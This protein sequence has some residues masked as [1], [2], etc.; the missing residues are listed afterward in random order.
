VAAHFDETRGRRCAF[1]AF[2][3]AFEDGG[4]IEADAFEKDGTANLAGADAGFG[5][6]I[7]GVEAA[8]DADRE[9][10]SGLAA[11]TAVS[12]ARQSATVLAR[13]FSQRC[14]CGRRRGF[15]A[16]VFMGIGAGGDDD[17]VNGGIGEHFVVVGIA[18]G[19]VEFVLDLP[20]FVAVAAQM[21]MTSATGIRCW[22]LVMWVRP[23]PPMPTTPNLILFMCCSCK[24]E[25]PD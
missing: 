2:E 1:D 16:L 20:D 23:M 5:F 22:R 10:R 12:T 19:D 24:Q 4:G 8:H 7:G 15:E 3:V 18:E 9:C 14:V 17:G 21:A 6:G 13:G 11:A 25:R